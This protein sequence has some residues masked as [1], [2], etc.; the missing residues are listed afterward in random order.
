[1]VFDREDARSRAFVRRGRDGR[2]WKT[3]ARAYWYGTLFFLSSR[4]KKQTSLVGVARYDSRRVPAAA[5]PSRLRRA[6]RS[7]VA[8]GCFRR[9]R[10]QVLRF[11][12]LPLAVLPRRPARDGEILLIV[13]RI[14]RPGRGRR[15]V[16]VLPARS[17]ALP[18]AEREKR[19]D[20]D[21]EGERGGGRAPAVVRARGAGEEQVRA[22]RRERV[23]RRD[24]R[25]G[26]GGRG[27]ARARRV[28]A[29]G[30]R[31]RGARG[32][33]RRRKKRGGARASARRG[34]ERRDG[35]GTPA[36]RGARLALVVQRS[37]GCESGV[38]L[39][40]SRAPAAREARSSPRP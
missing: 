8:R 32:G 5:G 16:V 27:D 7:F 9:A 10:S 18:R 33:L 37:G 14:R 24:E 21:E 26:R 15:G 25:R 40:R 38:A 31:A 35:V 30:A 20:G 23:A 17:A 1:M 29:R 12:G 34:R 4:R 6:L 2:F 11:R 28:G 39:G 36:T 13:F 22:D 3:C 19:G